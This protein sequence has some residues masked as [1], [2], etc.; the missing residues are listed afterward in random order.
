MTELSTPHPRA[1]AL[2]SREETKT[3]VIDRK[4]DIPLKDSLGLLRGSLY[5]PIA[6]GRCSVLITCG[7]FGEV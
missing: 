5:R 1:D 7:L 3:M 2:Y 6:P 4:L